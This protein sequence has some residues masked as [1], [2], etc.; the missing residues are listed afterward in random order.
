VLALGMFEEVCRLLRIT[1]R[2]K[3]PHFFLTVLNGVWK[4]SSKW[5]TSI[6]K[7]PRVQET[8]TERMS[9]SKSIS[10]GESNCNIIYVDPQRQSTQRHADRMIAWR[11]N[12]AVF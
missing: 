12:K 11:I 1:A 3:I 2:R 6:S 7:S 9:L 10:T 8:L 4:L 5:S